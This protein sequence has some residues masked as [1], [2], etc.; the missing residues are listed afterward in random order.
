MEHKEWRVE[1]TQQNIS[2]SWE[3]KE[4][5]TTVAY[6]PNEQTALSICAAH[7]Q[8]PKLVKALRELVKAMRKY[9]MDTDESPPF[10]H[11]TLMAKAESALAK[12]EAANAP[13]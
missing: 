4:D 12:L 13:K 6:C 10:H 5:K 2:C 7:N 8:Q 9:E 11:R 1:R 3:V